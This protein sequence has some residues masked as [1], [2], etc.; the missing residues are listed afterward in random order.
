MKFVCAAHDVGS[1]KVLGPIA[2][3]LSRRDHRV[4]VFTQGPA[5]DLIRSSGIE[6]VAIPE[7]SSGMNFLATRFRD[8]RPNCVVTGLS[9]PPRFEQGIHEL[10]NSQGVPVVVVED[11]PGA[12]SVRTRAEVAH[13]FATD[14]LSLGLARERYPKAG[15]VVVGNVGAF[16]PPVRA[17]V[18]A[19]FNGV[20]SQYPK[21][22]R[23]FVFTESGK[24]NDVAVEEQIRLLGACVRLSNG[25]VRVISRLDRKWNEEMV[26]ETM[27]LHQSW[28]KLLEDELGDCLVRFDGGT[29][30]DLVPLTDGVISVFSTVLTT[31]AH[32]GKVAVS[33]STS[34]STRFMQEATGLPYLPLV[35]LGLAREVRT[36]TDLRQLQPLENIGALESFNAA[37]ACDR[38]EELYRRV[39]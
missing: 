7:G 38:L 8:A 10:S 32:C 34:A 19:Q 25:M 12:A 27:S 14:V 17:E 9:W 4:M 21:E 31:A 24:P 37:R 1:A 6:C 22:T 13:V 39:K 11:V 15:G 18:A 29:I 23:L 20:R 33:L 35:R 5:T 2:M 30:D 36:P 16:V 26:T 28:M 3:A